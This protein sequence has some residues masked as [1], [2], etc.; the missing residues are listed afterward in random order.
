MKCKHAY[1][2][3]NKA[4]E[5]TCETCLDEQIREAYNRGKQE[6]RK[7]VLKQVEDKINNLWKEDE[8]SADIVIF[9]IAFK[10]KLKQSIKEI[11]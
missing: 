3:L 2:M 4:E 8:M 5:L 11:K 6:E 1:K 10:D 7:R 9:M